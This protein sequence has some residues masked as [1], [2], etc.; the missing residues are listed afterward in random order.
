MDAHDL[1]KHYAFKEA[2]AAKAIMDALIRVI[3]MHSMFPKSNPTRQQ[4][5]IWFHK[6]LLS[7]LG[8]YGPLTL[9][10]RKHQF[11]YN[12]DIILKDGN[13]SGD[14]AFLLYCDGLRWLEF[15]EGIDSW[16]VEGLVEILHRYT[17]RS[18]ED[19]E[20]DLVTALW[21]SNLPHIQFEAVDNILEVAAADDPSVAGGAREEGV[22][23]GERPVSNPFK[24]WSIPGA[25]PIPLAVS[26]QAAQSLPDQPPQAHDPDTPVIPAIGY[27]AEDLSAEEAANLREMVAREE[28]L[29]P[30]QEL[31]QTLVDILE[32]QEEKDLFT[33]VLEYIREE[34]V[35]AFTT[36]RFEVVVRIFNALHH[37]QK[38]CGPER[39]WVSRQLEDLFRS[40]STRESLDVVIKVATEADR[41][42]LKEIKE[43]LQFLPPESIEGMVP[44][45]LTVWS[46]QV[47][48]TLTEVIVVLARRDAGPIERLIKKA[49]DSAIMVLIDILGEVGGPRAVQILL[50]L[51][52]HPSEG[53]PTQVINT[54]AR[55][56]AWC[57]EKVFPLIGRDSPIVRR[58]LLNYLQSQKC[59]K[60]EALLMNYIS[61]PG[62]Q[63]VEKTF[64]MN[65]YRALGFCGSSKA[66]M[67]LRKMLLEG[68]RLGRLFNSPARQGAAVGLQALGSDEAMEILE[69]AAHSSF[70]GV[71]QAVRSVR[72]AESGG[73]L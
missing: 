12:N 52:D 69:K 43:C 26:S 71:R 58:T 8:V 23:S 39:A 63:K 37:L 30:T 41:S 10:I 65:C 15:Q 40:L 60:A 2:K 31:L 7:F 46:P 48:E 42:Q 72:T 5:L 59:E 50:G 1:E 21:D 4:A 25:A 20:E 64:A 68:S 57:P 35:K 73:S 6:N 53:V 3:K 27:V 56:K 19:E 32:N 22:R 47:R 13:S 33:A 54:L 70:P 28:E 14:F 66:L 51:I 45:L 44:L 38:H 18:V 11:L 29:D 16:E 24:S 49:N 67:F 55:L 17:K 61:A 34:L 9:E 36:S 62:F